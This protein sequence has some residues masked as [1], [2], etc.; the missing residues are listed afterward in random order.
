MAVKITSNNGE[1]KIE[2]D[3]VTQHYYIVWELS[4]ISLGKTKQEALE[5]LREAAHFGVDSLIDQKLRNIS[6]IITTGP[7]FL[8]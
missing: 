8:K 4:V 5:S 2:L 1:I 3:K 6:E 7:R